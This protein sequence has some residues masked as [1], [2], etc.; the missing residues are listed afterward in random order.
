MKRARQL[1]V[2]VASVAAAF[3]A[4]T[5]VVLLIR[6]IGSSFTNDVLLADPNAWYTVRL[7]RRVHITPD[8]RLLRFS[9]RSRFQTLGL[10]VGQHLLL[11]AR[12]DGCSVTR[13]YTPVSRCDQAGG[14][15]IMV[16]VYRTGTTGKFPEVGGMSQFLDMVCLGTK[17]KIQGPR[18][19]FL[20]QGQ[21]RFV[22]V[23]GSWLPPATWLG[24]VAAGSGVTPMLQLLRHVLADQTDKTK[25]MM[26]DV[27]RTEED[28]IA[29]RELDNYAKVQAERFSLCHVLSKPPTSESAITYVAGPLTPGIMAEHLPSP[30]A[31]TIV[32]LCGPREFLSDLC[33]PALT[34]IGHKTQRVLCF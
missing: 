29:R 10:S 23:D 14:F 11:C 34:A 21:G 12:I 24:L 8:V 19:R 27:N 6:K 31:E 1:L 4:F 26:I 13:P 20:Y 22:T 7:D 15:D 3:G 33:K 5:L 9:F 17:L 25:I 32:L 2:V 30:T 16:K 28:I 18:G